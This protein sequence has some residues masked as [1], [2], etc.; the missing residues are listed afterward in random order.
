MNRF[1][2]VPCEIGVHR[3]LQEGPLCIRKYRRFVYKSYKPICSNGM[4]LSKPVNSQRE[5]GCLK[6][7]IFGNCIDFPALWVI[8]VGTD[9]CRHLAVVYANN[10]NP[11]EQRMLFVDSLIELA[12]LVESRQVK[13]NYSKKDGL[14]IAGRKETAMS[15]DMLFCEAHGNGLLGEIFF[16]LFCLLP[17]GELNFVCVVV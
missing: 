16:D 13:T 2:V 11:T 17:S 8:V 7:N 1:N 6:I 12:C 10:W 4:R 15:L 5:H 3:I 14:N 9:S